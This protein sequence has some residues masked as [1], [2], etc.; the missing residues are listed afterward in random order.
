L[1][2]IAIQLLAGILITADLPAAAAPPDAGERAF[3][4]CYSCHAIEPG[5]ND[6][7][8]PSLHGII[9]RPIASVEGF[10]YSPALRRFAAANPRWTRALID[11]FATD[12]ETLVPRT[13]MGFHGIA[14]A[15]ERQALLDYL[16]RASN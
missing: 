7:T 8:G 9:G 2:P 6:L 16:A 3:Q 11:R 4:K 15:A 14:D 5:R 1:K 10:D 12:P 13:A